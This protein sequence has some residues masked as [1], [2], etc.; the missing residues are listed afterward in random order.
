M[1][2]ERHF[3]GAILVIERDTAL[4]L[5]RVGE[6]SET[7]RVTSHARAQARH[8]AEARGRE[9]EPAL[10]IR[11][12]VAR[13]R[14]E[15]RALAA[16][17][18]DLT[19]RV[20]RPAQDQTAAP[21]WRETTARELAGQERDAHAATRERITAVAQHALRTVATEAH[22]LQPSRGPTVARGADRPFEFV[23]AE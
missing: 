1:P 13:A 18:R 12:A 23:P 16:L 8:L 2:G 19:P 22:A 7:P 15:H 6:H 17:G 21:A 14:P 20:V 3:E 11:D 10:A 4:R 5:M 9:V